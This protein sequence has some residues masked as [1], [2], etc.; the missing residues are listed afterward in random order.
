MSYNNDDGESLLFFLN[1]DIFSNLQFSRLKNIDNNIE[2]VENETTLKKIVFS[3]YFINGCVLTF[4]L[5]FS[6]GSLILYLRGC[7]EIDIRDLENIL[8]IISTRLE[9][10]KDNILEQLLI[11]ET[12]KTKI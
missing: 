4:S 10:H 11:M 7:C 8:N 2:I 12:K 1:R 3:V 5:D 6:I 9:I